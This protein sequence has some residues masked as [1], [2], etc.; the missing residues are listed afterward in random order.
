MALGDFAS[1]QQLAE[2]MGV[3][4]STLYAECKAGALPGAYRV[5]RRIIVH[6]ATFLQSTEQIGSKDGNEDHGDAQR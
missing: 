1:I 3:H 4:P 2:A 6:V 5:G